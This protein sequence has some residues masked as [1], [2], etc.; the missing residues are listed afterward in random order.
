[1]EISHRKEKIETTKE[2]YGVDYPM[3]NIEIFKRQQESCFSKD[4]NGLH[5]YEPFAYKFLK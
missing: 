4:E 2:N 3:Q 1:M 5:G